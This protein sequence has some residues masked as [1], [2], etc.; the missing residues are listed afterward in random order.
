MSGRQGC[1]HPPHSRRP[2]PLSLRGGGLAGENQGDRSDD[3]AGGRTGRGR[4]NNG[5]SRL[6][7]EISVRTDRLGIQAEPVRGLLDFGHGRRR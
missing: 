6:D 4:D 7:D 5:L 2:A 3:L 1:A